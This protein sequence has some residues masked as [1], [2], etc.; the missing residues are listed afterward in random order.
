MSHPNTRKGNKFQN[1]TE[2]KLI[3]KSLDA[4]LLPK[5]GTKDEGDLRLR[6][7]D[8]TYILELKNEGRWNLTDYMR[9]AR[10]EAENYQ[11][12]KGETV[13][14]Y[15]AVLKKRQAPIMDAFVVVPL[16]EWLKQI[17]A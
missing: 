9:Q 11:A 12:R 14:S 13:F 15:A 8:K 4:D 16:H 5:R 1:D 17:G 10:V 6:V 2:R 7:E 3:E